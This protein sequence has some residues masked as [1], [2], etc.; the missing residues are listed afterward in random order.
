MV[1]LSAVF[2]PVTRIVK[3]TWIMTASDHRWVHGWFV[4]DP[5][6][7]IFLVVIF[8][9]FVLLEGLAGGTAGKRMLRLRVIGVNGARV[10][11]GGALLRNILRI[12]DS[13]PTLGILGALLIARSPEKARFGDRVAGTR[14][15]RIFRS[16][17]TEEK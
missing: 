2:F 1:L 3:G 9:Y 15:I 11:L 17:K 12:V 16:G 7:L 4:T 8:F 13:F 6:C 10:G 14:V 5:L